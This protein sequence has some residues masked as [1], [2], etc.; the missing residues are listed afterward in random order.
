MWQPKEGREGGRKEE[1]KRK[2][3]LKRKKRKEKEIKNF[4]FQLSLM[5]PLPAFSLKS[6]E[7]AASLWDLFCCFPGLFLNSDDNVATSWKEPAQF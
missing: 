2:E 5:I 1:R 6:L 4:H 3:K 7:A